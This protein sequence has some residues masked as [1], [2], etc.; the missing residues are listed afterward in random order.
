VKNFSKEKLNKNKNQKGGQLTAHLL[1]NIGT[2]AF[3]LYSLPVPL[4]DFYLPSL[5]A[6]IWPW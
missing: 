5:I 4:S 2:D 1:A 3:L 6:G